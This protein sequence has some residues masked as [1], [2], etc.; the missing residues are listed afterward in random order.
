M[1]AKRS[2]ERSGA[3][4]RNRKFEEGDVV[5]GYKDIAG[6]DELTAMPFYAVVVG[7]Y[8]EPKGKGWYQLIRV[9][10]P[11]NGTP[12]G[13]VFMMMP[14]HLV[15]TEYPKRRTIGSRFRGNERLVER[16]CT[17]NCCA[18]E[19]IPASMIMKDGRFSWEKDY[20]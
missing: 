14:H 4:G 6:V 16:G 17:C 18:H 12:Y 19:A 8:T 15:P 3:I 7:Y 11:L 2:E 10:H 20:E 5:F 9:L 1:S 13:E